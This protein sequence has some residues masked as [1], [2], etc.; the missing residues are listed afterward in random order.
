[1]MD[2]KNFNEETEFDFDKAFEPAEDEAVNGEE[3]DVS[4]ED[5]AENASTENDSDENNASG[6]DTNESQEE[7]SSES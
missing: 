3:S 4:T 1:M 2:E 6:T 7:N 5:V